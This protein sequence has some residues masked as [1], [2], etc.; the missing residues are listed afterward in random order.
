MLHLQGLLLPKLLPLAIGGAESD[1]HQFLL[2][3]AIASAALG[4]NFGDGYLHGAYFLHALQGVCGFEPGE[5]RAVFID[6]SPLL[7]RCRGSFPWVIKDATDAHGAGVAR[8]AGLIS[9]LE[10]TQPY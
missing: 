9:E 5:L 6:S 3:E 7:G 4:Y 10:K 8:G 1:G 2:G